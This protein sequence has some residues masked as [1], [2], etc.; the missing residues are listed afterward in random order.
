MSQ[1]SL[2]KKLST[3]DKNWVLWEKMNL[4]EKF[5][6]WTKKFIFHQISKIHEKWSKKVQFFQKKSKLL[7]C[8]EK[9]SNYRELISKLALESPESTLCGR[10]ALNA[11]KVNLTPEARLKAKN[12]VFGA[13]ISRLF[14]FQISKKARLKTV[15]KTQ[16]LTCAMR[17]YDSKQPSPMIS[18][19]PDD[20][21]VLN[22]PFSSECTSEIKLEPWW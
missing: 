2:E 7:F 19:H 9:T 13:K 17:F 8:S 10:K 11:P 20:F 6:F 21:R 15:T 1:L 16:A 4:C 5:E 14:H 12:L 22:A 3:F 18:S